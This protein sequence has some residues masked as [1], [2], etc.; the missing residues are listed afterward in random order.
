MDTTKETSANIGCTEI[1]NY[2]TTED[3][4]YLDLTG[5]E[6]SYIA[7][8]KGSCPVGGRIPPLNSTYYLFIKVS[9]VVSLESLEI[10]IDSATGKLICPEVPGAINSSDQLIPNSGSLPDAAGN[11]PGMDGFKPP[12][13]INPPG[14]LIQ[15]IGNLPGGKLK[16][17]GG[18]GFNPT[19]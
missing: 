1:P 14:Q 2:T 8:F 11:L 16:I 9:D 19:M 10:K 7:I 6:E 18:D 12:R 17:P 4:K 3:I 13:E 5:T 15:G